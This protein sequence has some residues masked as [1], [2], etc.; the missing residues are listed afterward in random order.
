[1]T[2]EVLIYL[3]AISFGY[4]CGSIP[5]GLILT[6]LWGL[7]DIRQIGSGNIGATNVLRTGHKGVSLLTLLCDIGKAV[8]AVCVVRLLDNQASEIAG[9]AALIGH[10]Y[11]VWLKFKGGKGVASSLGALLAI[12]W[13]VGLGA[14]LLWLLA[15][16]IFRISSLG[17]LTAL[18]GAPLIA[19]YCQDTF[20]AVIALLMAIVV[21]FKHKDN[22]ARLFRNQEPKIGKTKA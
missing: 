14:V 12:N 3:V 6:R 4:L 17:A 16:A 21:Y 10:V 15:V 5:F 19:W 11:P 9:F 20:L 1:M 2:D 8:V 13:V 22:I 7:P 18:A